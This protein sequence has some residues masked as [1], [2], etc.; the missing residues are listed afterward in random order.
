MHRFIFVE[1]S[2]IINLNTKLNEKERWKHRQSNPAAVSCNINYPLR[3]QRSERCGGNNPAC[4]CRHLGAYKPYKLLPAMGD[5][6]D[7]HLPG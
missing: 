2:K 1:Y 6:W 3:N 4:A 7:K 5:I